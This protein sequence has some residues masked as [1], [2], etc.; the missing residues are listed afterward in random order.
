M[1]SGR[2]IDELKISLESIGDALTSNILAVPL[3]QRSYAWEESHVRDLF[4]D[5]STAVS[6]NERDYFVGS[7]V[8]T[9]GPG[10]VLDV[11]DGQQR[12]ASSVVL[13][14]AMRD[15]FSANSD[16]ERAT[17]L[18]RDYLVDRDFRTQE[19]RPRLRMNEIDNDFFFRRVLA[20]PDSPDRSVAPTKDSHLRIKAAAELA[21][22][23]IAA[24]VS[25]SNKPTERLIELKDYLDQY[26][27]VIWVRV[28]DDANAFVIF[29]TLNDRGLE[30]AISDLLK[31]FLFRMVEDRLSEAQRDWV[32]MI[33]TLE[34]VDSESIVIE[35]IRHLWS[36]T[37]GAT[38][39]RDLYS[40]I[41]HATKSKQAALN[42]AK[43]LSG[44]A[45]IYAAIINTDHA[46]WSH[47]GS[48]AK[49][50]MTTMNLLGMVQIRPLLLAVL[51]SFTDK[52]I[53]NALRLMVSWG[54]R[55]LITGGLGGG[56]MEK[57]YSDSAREI[58]AGKIK[59]ASRLAEL[60]VGVV[61]SDRE[62]EAA[63]AIARVS[64][65]SLAR[66]Y[67][68]ALER[69][70]SG[71]KQPELVPNVNQDEVSLEHV[72]P[73]S[74]SANWPT[75]SAEEAAAYTTR[76][77]NLALL[78]AGVN[79]QVGSVPF[80]SKR[81]ILS[82]SDFQLTKAIGSAKTWAPQQI[83]AR[84]LRLA[85]LAVETWSLK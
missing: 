12:L 19:A 53:K 64:K 59:T 55:F 25:T 6:S 39:E 16:S 8:V 28:P 20:A 78:A 47:L 74:P 26:V 62:F 4:Q 21:K 72:L 63:F 61:P 42:L 54:V 31:N 34:A 17:Q 75:F 30:L 22:R 45:K 11:V 33:A 83:E 43:D 80:A 5:I 51:S 18:E 15:W 1:S 35:F 77:G 2:R 38:R 85:K 84:Q 32:A 76:L 81:S 36:S 9:K 23:H 79:S 24:W 50:H 52:E 14:A 48:T 58:R 57:Y 27:Q 49:G 69:Q 10:V 66:Y 82:A 65:A 70:Q 56:T 3:Y 37:H 7:I 60:L 46:L 13:I 40:A 73:K 44:S 67:L 68:Q 29:E 41:K 71:E